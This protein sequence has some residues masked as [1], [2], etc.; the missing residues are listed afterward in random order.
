MVKFFITVTVA[1]KKV[2]FTNILRI[3]TETTIQEA[4]IACD[5]PIPKPLANMKK[6]TDCSLKPLCLPKEVKLLSDIKT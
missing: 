6:C 1:A 3:K 4:L 5:Y 2:E